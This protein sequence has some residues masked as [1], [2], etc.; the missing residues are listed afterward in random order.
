L[1]QKQQKPLVDA[2]S[3]RLSES[4]YSGN[5]RFHHAFPRFIETNK[6]INI[7]NLA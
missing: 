6:N 3:Q 4:L 5:D 7:P 2:P 1:Q